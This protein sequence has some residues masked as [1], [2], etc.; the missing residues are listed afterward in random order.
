MQVFVD[1]KLAV[2]KKNTSFEYVSENSLFTGSDSY[3]LAISF[4]VKDCQQN[5]G[6]F[7]FLFRKDVDKNDVILDCY[8]RDKV[9]F[10]SGCITITEVNEV[11]VKAQFLEGRSAQNFDTSFDNVYINRLNLGYPS[12]TDRQSANITCA[13]A[14]LPYPQ[15]NEVALPWVNNT[16]GNLQN[17]AKRENGV[18]N[19][20]GQQVLSFQPY[21]IYIIKRIFTV[22]GYTYDI[23][24]WENSEMKYLIIC[25]ALPSAWDLSNYAYALPHWSVTEF[26][27][28]LEKLLFGEF[29]IN[30]K[31]KHIAFHFTK[32]ELAARDAVR[33]DKVVDAYHTNISLDKDCDYVKNIL[34]S[35]NDNR[36][37]AYRSCQWYIRDHGSEA[38]E[39]NTLAELLAY[40]ETLKESG[41][42]TYSG[43]RT[44]G[45]Y[46]RG[47]KKDSPGHNL[48]YAKDVGQY[49]IMFCYDSIQVKTTTVRDE[50]FHWYK[51]YNRLEP[52]N[53]FGKIEYAKE[54]DEEEI[55]IVP[56]WLDDT[57]EEHGICIFNECGERGSV[58]QLDDD[59][60]NEQQTIVN[61]SG[62]WSTPGSSSGID[63]PSSG[64]IGN[65]ANGTTPVVDETDYND[66]ALAQAR[67]GKAIESGEE[68]TSDEYFDH[69]YVG[70]WDGIHRIPTKQPF[71]FIHSLIT[72]NDFNRNDFPYTL[73]LRRETANYNRCSLHQIDGKKKYSFSWI[74]DV[75]PDPKAVF[76]IWGKKYMC[77]KITAH[78]TENGMSQLLKGE[79]YRILD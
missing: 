47:Y 20:L 71:P 6:I 9:F 78:F 56:A 79:F 63:R 57:D 38:V 58:V 45:L 61:P 35:E 27:E 17:E 41:V 54:A 15:R 13:N 31:A 51:Y 52:I 7:G 11:E 66:G 77:E 42:Y 2:L 64:G 37:W 39:Y 26:L 69:I 43:G 72:T 34:Y 1:G 22:L 48:F 23:S 14:W 18:W 10:R 67:T 73:S 46:T 19:W 32:N 3:T 62:G 65:G 21:L 59:E 68:D 76:Y 53:Q 60:D 44:G 16:S 74:S 75:V 25:N 30:H 4:P 40:A 12:G 24:E 29:Q 33:I 50:E 28:E 5:M 36:F 70:Y 8:M 55:R 49:F